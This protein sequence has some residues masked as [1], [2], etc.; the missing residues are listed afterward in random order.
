MR[1]VFNVYC[2]ESCHLE[3][4]NQKAMVLGAV[5]SP[6]NKRKEINTRLRE[7]KRKH[8]TE[9]GFEAK[10]TKVGPGKLELYMDLI[11]YFFDDD[12]LCFRGLVIP[13]KNI[14][15]H[16]EFNQSHDDWYYKMYFTM[17]KTIFHPAAQYRVYIDIKDTWGHNKVEQLHEV[18]CNNSYDYSK[19]IISR[20]QQ[21][22][23][24]EAEQL[25]LT[26]LLIGALSYLH[27]NLE[28]S[29]A[30]LKLIKRIKT[31]AGY[32]LKNNTLLREMKFNLLVWE[33][34]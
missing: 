10:W 31:R 2:D 9:P 22:R 6:E 17:L 32:T 11:D 15:G 30:K 16:D 7:I 8:K 25:Q 19:K 34:K 12:D 23:S 4:D 24:H 13:D 1:E 20:V 27:R 26:D 3:N 18:L 21:V 28:G 14:L 29:E 5:W 33:P